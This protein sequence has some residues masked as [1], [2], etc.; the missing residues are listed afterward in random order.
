MSDIIKLLPEHVANQIAAGEVIQRPASIVKELLDNSIDAGATHIKLILKD[1]GKALVQVIDNGKG[2]SETDARMCWE[3]H[4]TSKIKSIEDVFKIKTMGFRGEALASVASV[5]Q[6]ELKTKRNEDTVG[7][8]I[9]IEGSNIIKQDVV[10]WQTGTSISVKNL[11]FNIPARRNFLKSNPVELRHIIDEFT[12]AALA[13][14]HIGFE[15]W[16]NDDQMHNLKPADLA[17]R[18]SDLFDDKKPDDLLLFEEHT[19]IINASGFIGKPQI[20]KKTRGDQYIFVNNRFIKDAYLNHA[21]VSG[22]ENIIAKDQYPFYCINIEID[23]SKIDVNIHPTKTE[24]KFEDERNIYQILRA[25]T[26]KVLGENF[27]TPT[28]DKSYEDN[29]FLNHD[30][31]NN[32]ATHFNNIQISETQLVGKV[33]GGKNDWLKNEYASSRNFKKQ[34][35]TNWEDLFKIAAPDVPSE[36]PKSENNVAQQTLIE[37]N[38]QTSQQFLQIQ[39]TY[40]ATQIKSGLL[41][42]SQQAAHERIL[43]E[44]YLLAIKH[45]PIASQQKLFPKTINLNS[46]DE[47][48]LLEILPEIKTLGFDVNEFGKGTFVVNGVPAEM[49]YTNEQELILDLISNYK[50]NKNLADSK[51]ELIAKILAKKAAIKAGTVLAT[52]EMNRMVDELFACSEP[53]YS[54]DGKACLLTLSM[55]DLA[56]MFK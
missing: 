30:L 6:V 17:F 34:Q 2:M 9:L 16:H 29:Q 8:Y 19:T 36:I 49:Q 31:Y 28:L 15:L 52:D 3:R 40:I 43:F 24:V 27:E 39:Q 41:L 47:S 7:T 20:A 45:Q 22:F 38:K 48:I 11:F 5:A 53:K 10:S 25:V 55:A 18:I 12:R 1:A 4:A 42:I 13:N 44:K 50:N 33:S 37:N 51:H 56:N 35:T 26:R 54:P 32:Q 23:P 46:I 14:P 21:I